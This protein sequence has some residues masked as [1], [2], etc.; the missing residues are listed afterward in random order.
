MRIRFLLAL[1]V[2]GS[3]LVVPGA[4][5]AATYSAG[6][7]GPAG[8][9]IIAT[10][11]TSGNLTGM[12]FEAAPTPL[13]GKFKWCEEADNSTGLD[14]SVNYGAG[15]QNTSLAAAHCGPASAAAAANAYS[16]GGFNDW[17]LPS[18]NELSA[19][20]SAE[21]ALLNPVDGLIV[22][23]SDSGAQVSWVTANYDGMSL[24]DVSFVVFPI[25]EFAAP[26]QTPT[27]GIAS[28]DSATRVEIQFTPPTI[29]GGS[30]ILSY[31]AI[32]SPGEESVTVTDTSTASIYFDGLAE[33]TNY[34]FQVY[35]TNAAGDGH[36]SAMSNSI[37]T[38]KRFLIAPSGTIGDGSTCVKP[39]GVGVASIP[40][41]MNLV[42]AYA[43]AEID[44]VFCPGNYSVAAPI[45]VQNYDTTA[46]LNDISHVAGSGDR[47]TFV[48]K[49]LVN[50]SNSVIL[51][52]GST[53]SIFKVDT[54]ASVII[55]NLTLQNGL[56]S[57]ESGGAINITYST[58]NFSDGQT[59]TQI[60]GNSFIANSSNFGGG[61]IEVSGDDMGAGDIFN[62]LSI[63]ENGFYENSAGVDGGALSLD[64]VAFNPVKIEL[65]NNRFAYNHTVGRSGG[66]ISSNFN[67]ATLIG[68]KFLNNYA[69]AGNGQIIY[70]NG[71]TH[72]SGNRLIDTINQL[73]GEPECVTRPS[74]LASEN[75]ASNS[76]CTIAGTDPA[77]T[78]LEKSVAE[79]FASTGPFLPQSPLVSTD[80]G[81]LSSTVSTV[82]ISLDANQSDGGSAVTNHLYSINGSPFVA[83]NP[84]QYGSRISITGLTPSTTYSLRLKSQNS[85]GLSAPS[86]I[87][88]FTTADPGVPDAPVISS[89]SSNGT[90]SASVTFSAPENNGGSP[91]T[92]Y[93][94]KIYPSE[95]TR[96]ATTAGSIT[97][98]GLSPATQY[99]FTMTAKNSIGESASSTFSNF[100]TTDSL[101]AKRAPRDPA[102][103][104]TPNPLAGTSKAGTS[105][106]SG[107]R[108]AFAQFLKQLRELRAAHSS[109]VKEIA[110]LAP[111]D[112]IAAL[113]KLR[114]KES[115]LRE[116]Y[117]SERTEALR[118]LRS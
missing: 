15:K 113:K 19:L 26:P 53:S 31:T 43:G 46:D 87:I 68:N 13:P 50:N 117:L 29:D 30:P 65:K 2:L 107:A 100:V 5:Y 114:L 92:S 91:I 90:T 10:P 102:D 86:P 116:K 52:G 3:G 111:K 6:E 115:A 20:K 16:F 11:D 81:S 77:E 66:A 88:S 27:I 84:A 112:R 22:S 48:F 37:V 105:L 61:A 99:R 55:K 74:D 4:A 51:D 35:A 73:P 109:A 58:S 45:R 75:W 72:F 98:S 24:K 12:Y 18:V 34:T 8:G 38:G 60:L 103:T 69:P 71:I 101:P 59:S 39:D 80:A 97:F 17:F 82:Q 41:L 89:V 83:L 106:A 9:L 23:S 76:N 40:G 118:K 104:S 85:V 93:V 110:K 21:G 33:N 70:T 54:R 7:V 42:N 67:S 64:A 56:N 14:T 32:A 47:R 94:A 49:S 1:V 25:R 62:K 28:L 96:T 57:V 95:E 36:A 79:I 63:F 78:W 108:A 44:F